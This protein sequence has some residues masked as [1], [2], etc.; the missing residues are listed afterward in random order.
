MF[1]LYFKLSKNSYIFN[2][3]SSAYFFGKITYR[4]YCDLFLI[5]I[6]S[7]G[8]TVE[9][10]TTAAALPFQGMELNQLEETSTFMLALLTALLSGAG[11]FKMLS[12]WNLLQINRIFIL[13]IFESPENL[14]SF[15]FSHYN[16]VEFQPFTCTNVRPVG[17]T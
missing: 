15:L 4:I 8:A 6:T 9:S 3:R 11:L 7:L 14:S 13:S 1:F 5:F 10:I 16:V 17:E 12:S 2:M